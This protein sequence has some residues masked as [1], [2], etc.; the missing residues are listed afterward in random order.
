MSFRKT[1]ALFL[2]LVTVLPLIYVPVGAEGDRTSVTASIAES[3]AYVE[4]ECT[5]TDELSKSTDEELCVFALSA[6][7]LDEPLSY[8]AP[9]KTG[10]AVRKS[11]TV[12]LPSSV[13]ASSAFVLA[14][15]NEDG[16]YKE[17]HSPVYVSNPDIL[18]K[19][20]APFFY[21]YTKKGLVFD[22][23][24]D[25]QQLGAGHTVIEIALNEYFTDSADGAAFKHG[26]RTYYFDSAKLGM[27]DHLVKIYTDAHIRVYFN[28]VLTEKGEE[29]PAILECLYYDDAEEGAKYYG[30][31]GKSAEALE[32]LS[33]AVGFLTE[34]YTGESGRYGFAASFIIGKEVNNGREMNASG[35]MPLSEYVKLYERVFRAADLA[36]RSKYK[37]A[38]LYVPVGNNFN[39]ASSGG[40]SDPMLDY[41]AKD[42][43]DAF[44]KNV[45]RGGDLPW[46]LAISPYNVDSSKADFWS[47]DIQLQDMNAEYITMDNIGALTTYLSGVDFLYGGEKR[48]VL[49]SDIAYT[50]GDNSDK[51]ERLQ[52]AAFALAYYRAEA[53]SMIEAIIWSRQTDD[54]RDGENFGLWTRES[55]TNNDPKDKKQI[56]NTFKY[57]DTESSLAA[58]EMLLSVIGA[59]SWGEAVSGYDPGRQENRVIYSGVSVLKDQVGAVKITPLFDFKKGAEGFYPSDNAYSVATGEKNGA[60]VLDAVMFDVF[61]AEYR[62]IH[63]DLGGK[64]DGAG[65]IALDITVNTE[66]AL[67]TADLCLRLTGYTEDGR[68]AV[69]EGTSVLETGAAYSLLFD[70]SEFSKGVA[71]IDDM[72]LW[73]APHAGEEGSVTGFTVSSLGCVLQAGAREGSALKTLG[74]I[75]LCI[76]IPA[77]VIFIALVIKA[78]FFDTKRKKRRRSIRK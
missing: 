1:A 22:R 4:L 48:S 72:K 29:L 15:M 7:E 20:G 75:A 77:A 40:E 53:N 39:V 64:A 12:Q 37:Y 36:A 6:S 26:S 35:R 24:A 38:R 43:I 70:V 13:S 2:I 10:I 71:S 68:L 67:R 47:S 78:N 19:E 5:L 3:G 55:G 44:S 41:S 32:Y 49:I 63:C 23:F 21:G 51:A 42:F 65:Y 69:Y 28:I 25:A 60:Y 31:N 18:A 33:A 57:I 30:I 45:K 54:S 62:G 34:R 14:A 74:I 17:L 11:F 59:S 27:L 8:R 52:A 56:Y 9:V 61:S 50:G 58:T 66:N 73:I 16:E 76:V 46:N